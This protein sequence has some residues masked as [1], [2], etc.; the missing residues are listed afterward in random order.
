MQA[1]HL[2]V[3]PVSHTRRWTTLLILSLSVTIGLD[4]AHARAQEHSWVNP[5]PEG[6]HPR[7]THG[8][9]ESA[10]MGTEVGYV[11]YLPPGYD[12]PSNVQ[13][14]YPVVYY[15]H[16][17]LS[18]TEVRSIGM[19]AYFDRAI[20]SD[21]VPPRIYV[22][23]NGGR[24][25]HYDYGDFLAET[26]FV[27]ELIPHIDDTYRT[28]SSRS[29]RGLEGFSAGGRGTARI[30][31]KHPELFCSA[32][33]MAGGHQQ[34]RLVYDGRPEESNS[35]IALD[36][37]YSSWALAERYAASTNA[38]ELSILVV[39]GTDDFNYEANLEWMAHLESLSIGFERIIVP[40][41]PH[42]TGQVYDKV[43]NDVMRF[44]EGCF[45]E[46]HAP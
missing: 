6:A 32:A 12:A 29:G 37:D 42:A 26:A 20:E 8:T 28:I 22:F 43:G 10:S 19:A 15:L 36:A 31:F 23:V 1:L 34:E 41:V 38:P 21:I 46:V 11:I 2:E 14:R 45:A 27:D 16:G 39:V 9:F 17:G 44:H 30:M 33:P 35:A 25:S 7:L 40:D 24:H 18:G 4:P 13:R 3:R 5:L